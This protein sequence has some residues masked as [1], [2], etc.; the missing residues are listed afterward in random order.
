LRF[1]VLG[2]GA[3]GGY[4]GAALARGGSDVT[5]IARGAHLAA[6]AE[7]GVKVLS[8]RGNFSAWPDV[9]DDLAALSDAEVV[10]IGLKAYSLPALAP[11]IAEYLRPGTAVI[12]AQN[13][14]PWWFFQRTGDPLAGT[15]LESV[16]PS[17]IIAEA[18][19]PEQVIGTVV[20]CSTEIVEPGVIRH[21]EG[22]R[23]PLAEID[24]AA[25]E[26]CR[27]IARRFVAGGLKAP[28]EPRLRELIW[29]KLIGNV[30]F[31]PVS[32]LT[33]ATLRQLS[34]EPT[35]VA[36]LSDLMK[37]CA[38]VGELLGLELPVS[39]ERRLSAGLEVGD[40]KTSM[41]QDLLAGKPLEYACMTGAT[42]ELA[43]LL[44]IAVPRIQAVHACMACL[45]RTRR[46]GTPDPSI[47]RPEPE[48]LA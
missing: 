40:H 39:I 25:S 9:T 2:A 30:A 20:F 15:V 44:G 26:R 29:L 36:L 3:I 14:V 1:A 8:P 7:S 10:F 11:R 18:I 4:V 23:F 47:A 21:I 34:D 42:V 31:N 48:M 43:Q 45:A 6:M 32:A 41:L 12:A 16:D 22:S 24:G 33:G 37:E 28:V 35:M 46:T 13:G 17:G 19:A 38:A 5:L 27:A